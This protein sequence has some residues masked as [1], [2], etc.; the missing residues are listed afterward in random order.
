MLKVL[1]ILVCFGCCVVAGVVCG[2]HL[3]KRSN[4]Y[5]DLCLFCEELMLQIKG[6]LQTLPNFVSSHKNMFGREFGAVLEQY[7]MWLAGK[8]EEKDFLQFEVAS[9]SGNEMKDVCEFL[10]N[11]GTFLTDEELAKLE[12]NKSKF[13][14][15][16][17][18]CDENKG[19]FFGTYIKLFVVAGAMLAII[20]L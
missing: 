20:F 17:K 4:F 7:E 3:K 1:L 15:K 16:S 9:I 13:K 2:S 11:L 12:I 5:S 10:M 8:I 14:S 19:K 6:N 18:V